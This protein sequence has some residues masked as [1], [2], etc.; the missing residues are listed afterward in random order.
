MTN[1]K[2]SLTAQVA[3]RLTPQVKEKLKNIPNWQNQ[4]RDFIEDMT[5]DDGVSKACPKDI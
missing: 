2:Q 1:R 5:K 4:V 3:I